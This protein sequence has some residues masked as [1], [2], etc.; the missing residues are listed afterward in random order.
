MCNSGN[1]YQP[2]RHSNY[3]NIPSIEVLTQIKYEARKKGKLNDEQLLE[4]VKF[5]GVQLSKNVNFIREI[6]LV[7]VRI[8]LM[9]QNIIKILK[10]EIKCNNFL[11]LYFH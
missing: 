7:Q 3:S 11:S 2:G 1:P 9:H 6:S 5:R 4:T 8:D 10:L